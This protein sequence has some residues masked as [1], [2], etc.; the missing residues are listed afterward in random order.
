MNQSERRKYLIQSLMDEDGRYC[1]MEIPADAVDQRVL[2]RGL[3]NVRGC[4]R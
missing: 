1:G 3:M 4:L 2:L